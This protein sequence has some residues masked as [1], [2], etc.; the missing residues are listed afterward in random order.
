MIRHHHPIV[1][2]ILLAVKMSE[3]AGNRVRN[4]GA[5]QMTFADAVVEITFNF[6]LE[7]TMNFLGLIGGGFGRETAQRFGV[8]LLEAEQPFFRQRIHEPERDEVILMSFQVEPFIRNELKSK[9]SRFSGFSSLGEAVETAIT[10][11]HPCHRAEAR[12]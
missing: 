10:S 3:G 4:F 8:F 1:E 2:Q 12:C 5:A 6:A 7:F 9:S 11:G